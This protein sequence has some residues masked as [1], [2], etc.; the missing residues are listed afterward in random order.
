MSSHANPT[1]PHTATPSVR[2]ETSVSQAEHPC[3]RVPE[4]ASVS[5]VDPGDVFITIAG[6]SDTSVVCVAAHNSDSK[7]T[8]LAPGQSAKRAADWG[9]DKLDSRI[10]RSFHRLLDTTDRWLTVEHHT[11]P[12]GAEA[13][14]RLPLDGRAEPN[15]GYIVSLQP[16]TLA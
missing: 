14:H 4:L 3:I 13:V 7:V 9:A 1:E 6:C 8:S 10:A 15:I 12:D 11:G 5:G 2:R 16:G